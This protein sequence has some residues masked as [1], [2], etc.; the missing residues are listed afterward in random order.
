M[1]KEGTAYFIP[2]NVF[3]HA[4]GDIGKKKNGLRIM[5]NEARFRSLFGISP[6][7]CNLVLWILGF[8]IPHGFMLKHLMWALLFLK[9]YGS[10]SAN[11]AL[12]GADEK[13]IRKRT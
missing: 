1:G 3:A 5:S 8:S 4:G 6:E 10:G 7:I 9:I 2:S 11:C 13:T 12:T